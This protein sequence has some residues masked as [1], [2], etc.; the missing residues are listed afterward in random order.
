MLS[1]D[2]IER[3]WHV[4]FVI[5]RAVFTVDEITALRHRAYDALAADT[6]R[7]RAERVGAVTFAKGDL[8]SKEA[9]RGVLLDPR[10]VSIAG[11][12]LGGRPAYFGDSNFQIG[13][14]VRGWHKDNRMPDRYMFSA[15]DWDGRYPLIRLGIYMQDHTDHSG[16]LGVR[17]GSHEPSRIGRWL[18]RE[19]PFVGKRVRLAAL[20]RLANLYGRPISVPTR[21]GDVVAWNLRTTH[22]GNAVRLRGAPRIKL[23]P[24]IEDRVP[25]ALRVEEERERVA[26]FM[27]FARPG[28]HLSRYVEYLKTRPDAVENWRNSPVSDDVWRESGARGVDLIRPVPEYGR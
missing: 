2:A 15:P 23:P 6:A 8:L 3:F 28:D 17:V 22:S 1:H 4:G 27:T 21:V 14:G 12:L 25:R 10:I 24:G 9:L 16:G 13:E 11:D 19:L 18:S 20:S 26:C 7:G 5:A